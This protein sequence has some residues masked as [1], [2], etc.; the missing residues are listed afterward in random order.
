MG[1]V[2]LEEKCGVLDEPV[3]SMSWPDFFTTEHGSIS[4]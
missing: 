4:F 2:L 1:T 3:D